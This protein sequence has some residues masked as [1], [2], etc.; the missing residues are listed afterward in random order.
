MQKV[1][2]EKVGK[3]LMKI[4]KK[5]EEEEKEEKK[6]IKIIKNMKEGN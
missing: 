4:V 5:K 2:K 6:K 1:K 3:E